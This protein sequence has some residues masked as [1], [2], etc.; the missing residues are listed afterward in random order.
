MLMYFGFCFLWTCAHHSS[1]VYPWCLLVWVILSAVCLLSLGP[2][3]KTRSPGRL[4]ALAVAALL[5]SLV[6]VGSSEE[7]RSFWSFVLAAADL[8]KGL[9]TVGS[10]EE[11]SS[12]C[13]VCSCSPR[14]LMNYSFCFP[15]CSRTPRKLS[16]CWFS[17]HAWYWGP[18]RS[19]D[20]GVS[21]PV[22]L[23]AAENLISLGY[24]VFR[25]AD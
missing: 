18:G 8:L 7:Q 1:S 9:Q 6:T 2:Q 19:S 11:Q 21:F 23:C 13:S 20:C 25:E 5:W 12:C 4:V 15:V 17:C 16:E 14:R 3:H 22:T 24:V 10:S